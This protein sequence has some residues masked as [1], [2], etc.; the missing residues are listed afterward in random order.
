MKKIIFIT[1]VAL[2]VS[3]QPKT[4]KTGD[5]SPDIA[6]MVKKENFQG[7]HKDQQTD[8]FTIKNP[9]G[10]V[11]Q[12][13]NYGAKIVTLFVPDRDANMGDIV[14]GYKNIQEY[15]QSCISP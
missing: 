12:V 14:F 2:L 13:T 15:I 3:C 9:N 5:G 8:L 11:M 6:G 10:L 7:T 4:K 1:L